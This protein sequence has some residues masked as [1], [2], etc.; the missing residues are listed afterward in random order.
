MRR[1]ETRSRRRGRV[2]GPPVAEPGPS[3]LDWAREL[4]SI[5]QTGLTYASDPYD[6]ERYRRVRRLA[7]EIAASHT[8]EGVEAIERF[9]AS[10]SGY[11][12]PKIDVRAAVIVEGRILLVL[13]GDGTG[14]ALPGGWA[15]IGDSAAEATVRETREEAGLEVQAVKLIALHDRQRRGHPPH[16]EYSYKAF[17][18]CRALQDAEPRPGPETLDARFFDPG[19]LPSLS[20]ERVLREQIELAFTHHADP[21]LPTEF[22]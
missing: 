20:L 17:F 11:P 5:A 9:F 8:T 4:Q 7:A 1:R 18:A 21:G 19:G 15:D 3:W 14:W 6:A 10:E 16:P 22:D 13:E 2:S 12:T